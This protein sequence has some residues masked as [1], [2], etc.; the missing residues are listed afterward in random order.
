MEYGVIKLVNRLDATRFSS[1]ICCLAFQTDVTRPLLDKR[2]SV[3]ELRRQP[4]RDLRMIFR[5]AS[6]IRKER[7]DIV[8]S[9]NWPTFFYATMAAYLTWVPII[10]GEHGRESRAVPRRRVLLGKWLAKSVNRIVAV[11]SHLA[12]QLESLWSLRPGLITVIPNGVDV[13]RFGEEYVLDDILREFRWTNENR[14][15]LNVGG[16]RPVKDHHTLV[17][18][19]A[20]VYEKAPRARLLLVGSDHGSGIKEELQ[21][22][23][24]DLG[25]RNA[26]HFAGVRR[27]IPQLQSLCSVYANT[28]LFEGMSNTVLEAMAA[29]NPVIATDVGGNPELVEDGMTGFLFPSGN[30]QQLAE[31]LE[32]LLTNPHLAGE[33]GIAGRR[34]A[35]QK[36]SIFPMVRDYGGLYEGVFWRDRSKRVVRRR[37]R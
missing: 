15:V 18:A 3:H 12:C 16:L 21:N 1:L 36:H 27:D 28:S 14:V 30:D 9:H 32:Q 20:R 31:R 7:V 26:V 6:L 11:S 10:H 17:R 24:A 19:F 25:I 4:G 23:A 34:K 2:V 13:G 5:I 8:H 33:M 29:G 35:E 37:N 22:L